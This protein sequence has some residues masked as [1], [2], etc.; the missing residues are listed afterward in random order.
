MLTFY[1]ATRGQSWLVSVATLLDCSALLIAGGEG[2]LV[3]QARA[4]YRM[5]IRMLKD[6]TAALNLTVDPRCRV[7]LSKAELPTLLVAVKGSDLTLN[8]GPTSGIQLLR[9]VR[10]YDVY[11]LALSE[12][13]VIPLPPWIH[14]RA[15]RGQNRPRGAE[16]SDKTT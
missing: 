9:L 15:E 16:D 6:L 13:L 11:L 14:P 2:M 8:L 7:R 12:C 5:G 4:T 3:A 10:R 1:R